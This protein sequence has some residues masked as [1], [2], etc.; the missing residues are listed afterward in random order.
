MDQFFDQ[1]LK[2]FVDNS[3]LPWKWQSA[4]H[5]KLGLSA[6]ALGEFQRASEI[7]DALFPTGGSA[8]SVKFQLVPVS[9]DPGLAQVSLEAGGSRLTYAHGP[10]EPTAMVWPGGDGKTQVRFTATPAGGGASTVVEENGPWALLRLLDT[11]HV[12]S[13]GQPDRFT[14]TLAAPAGNAVFTLNAASVRNPFS[15]T[16]LRAFRCPSQL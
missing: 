3:E 1:Y 16:A 10:L 5:T 15:M 4:D 7:R 13:T 6:G 14:L 11:A 8:V 12:A 9:L 2:P